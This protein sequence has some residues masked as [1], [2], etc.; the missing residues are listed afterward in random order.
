[1]KDIKS[2]NFIELPSEEFGI[3][4]LEKEFIMINTAE[5]Y[6]KEQMSGEP[7]RQDAVIYGL[8]EFAT[9]QI[10]NIKD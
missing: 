6:F 7:L 5:L 4:N 3:A 1:M 2:E 8:A 10:N 9:Q